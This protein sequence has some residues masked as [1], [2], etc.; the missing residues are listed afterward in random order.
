[1]YI[2]SVVT[3]IFFLFSFLFCIVKN[4]GNFFLFNLARFTFIW[5]W[6]KIH[7]MCVYVCVRQ[8]YLPEH[9]SFCSFFVICDQTFA[10]AKY[11]A[12]LHQCQI[13][14]FIGCEKPHALSVAR[15]HMHYTQN[16]TITHIKIRLCYT[17]I[18]WRF[19]SFKHRV[20]LIPW[21]KY[22]LKNQGEGAGTPLK[23][24]ILGA[25]FINNNYNN[26]QN[27]NKKQKA[28]P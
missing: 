27:K 23:D 7:T 6:G 28:D 20:I 9:Y 26:K 17:Q 2:S 24:R 8:L 22:P 1:M 5:L 10:P 14:H 25:L 21:W 4:R 18:L 16:P 11:K 15:S 3:E 13:L 19:G 12:R